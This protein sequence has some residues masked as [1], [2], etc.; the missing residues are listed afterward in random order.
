MPATRLILFG[1]VP[2]VACAD[3]IENSLRY[4]QIEPLSL[5]VPPLVRDLLMRRNDQ[6]AAAARDKVAGN[7]GFDKR[8]PFLTSIFQ[9]ATR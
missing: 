9:R 7:R 2:T 4:E 5:V 8:T 1:R 6:I 3:F